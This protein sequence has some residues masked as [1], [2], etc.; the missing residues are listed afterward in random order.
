MWKSKLTIT[1]LIGRSL[2]LLV[3]TVIGNNGLLHLQDLNNKRDALSH[4]NRELQSDIAALQHKIVAVRRSNAALEKVAREE[5]S[6]A[7]E[8][9]IVYI[10]PETAK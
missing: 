10:F 7:R 9:E 6:L 4:K 8:D 1:L 3:L 5:L 2:A